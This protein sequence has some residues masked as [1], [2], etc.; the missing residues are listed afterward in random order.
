M[1]DN[2]IWLIGS[3]DPSLLHE[4]TGIEKWDPITNTWEE[5]H[6]VVSRPKSLLHDSCVVQA[7][8]KIFVIG[9]RAPGVGTLGLVERCVVC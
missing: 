4:M 5:E 2:K 3:H 6:G 9:G 8:G 7:N 1:P